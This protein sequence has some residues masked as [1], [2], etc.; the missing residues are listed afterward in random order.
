M[1]HGE[2]VNKEELLKKFKE[3]VQYLERNVPPDDIYLFT[4]QTVMAAL[5]FMF[6]WSEWVDIAQEAEKDPIAKK[7]ITNILSLVVMR[8]KGQDIE[9]DLN[10]KSLEDE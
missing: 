2:K 8:D 5:Y 10:M 4:E 3:N 1:L 9:I 7:W 6:K